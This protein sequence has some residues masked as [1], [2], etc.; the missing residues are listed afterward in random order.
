MCPRVDETVPF[1]GSVVICHSVTRHTHRV[2]RTAS[3]GS[4]R[5]LVG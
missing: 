4:D 3:V 1:Y 2:D 5:L